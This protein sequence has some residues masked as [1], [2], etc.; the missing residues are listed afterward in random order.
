MPEDDLYLLRTDIYALDYEKQRRLFQSFR[1]CVYRDLYF[2][3][4][5]HALAEDVLQ[6]SFMKAIKN[7]PK[8]RHDSNLTAWSRQVGRNTA[9]DFMRKNKKY[10]QMVDIE[11]VTYYN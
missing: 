11:D 2:L 7:G 4:G 10:R 5:E 1:T 9:Y 3:L 6:E 8:L